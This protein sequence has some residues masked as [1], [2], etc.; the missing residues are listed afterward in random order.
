MFQIDHCGV[1]PALLWLRAWEVSSQIAHPSPQ[2]RP[3]GPAESPARAT[4]GLCRRRVVRSVRSPGGYL[5]TCAHKVAA[6]S[7]RRLLSGRGDAAACCGGRRPEGP[8]YASRVDW[9]LV[10]AEVFALDGGHVAQRLVVGACGSDGKRLARRVPKPSREPTSHAP[11]PGRTLTAD[12][13]ASG[14][15]TTS[16]RWGTS[17]GTPACIVASAATRGE[18]RGTGDSRPPSGRRSERR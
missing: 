12:L 17:A 7:Q 11:G 18:L 10:Q 9:D 6:A 13:R 2:T 1:P 5:N 8:A 4:G 16:R 14:G 3:H 15:S